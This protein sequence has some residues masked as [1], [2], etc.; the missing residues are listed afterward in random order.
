MLEARLRRG[1]SHAANATA[2]MART[3][4]E[5]CRVLVVRSWSLSSGSIGIKVVTRPFD[6]R[7]SVTGST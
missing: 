3:A 4:A 2:T 1:P 5:K 6:Q 7:A